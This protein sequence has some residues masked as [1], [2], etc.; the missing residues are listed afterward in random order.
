MS[1]PRDDDDRW[2]SGWEPDEDAAGAILFDV[3]L[4]RLGADFDMEPDAAETAPED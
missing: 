3:H 4:T 1:G 2:W